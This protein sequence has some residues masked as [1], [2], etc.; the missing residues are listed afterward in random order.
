MNFP[1]AILIN[2]F[3]NREQPQLHYIYIEMYPL[4]GRVNWNPQHTR[5]AFGGGMIV[6]IELSAILICWLQ[7]KHT[8]VRK[9]R[10]SSETNVNDEFAC[11][12][13]VN[14]M[15][16]YWDRAIEWFFTQ[17]EC[18]NA[19][20]TW[21]ATAFECAIF[22][23]LSLSVAVGIIG[24]RVCPHVCWCAFGL[25]RCAKL[26]PPDSSIEFVDDSRCFWLNYRAHTQT[27]KW[28]LHPS[29]LCVCFCLW[30]CSSSLQR[31]HIEHIK[32]I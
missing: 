4:D 21:H 5:I 11:M 15:L 3:A 12:G 28:C 29:V 9:V 16:Y 22:G 23:M 2:N 20:E 25:T 13:C 8:S 32:W 26:S 27:P 30:F 7:R 18:W 19:I 17:S 24:A 10:W 1:P 14:T 31:V 6:H